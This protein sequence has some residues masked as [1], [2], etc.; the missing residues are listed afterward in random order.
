MGKKDDKRKKKR[1]YNMDYGQLVQRF[2]LLAML[3]YIMLEIT[4]LN[5]SAQNAWD[6]HN[7]L[8]IVDMVLILPIEESK[9]CGHLNPSL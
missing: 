7:I 4:I 1:D 3:T 2:L 5:N 6:T 8:F 9:I